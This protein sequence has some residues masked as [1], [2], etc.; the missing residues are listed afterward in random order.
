MLYLNKEAI[1]MDND[2]GTFSSY[3]FKTELVKS[4]VALLY[5]KLK[6]DDNRDGEITIECPMID[7]IG[8]CHLYKLS[9]YDAFNHELK[10]V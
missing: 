9:F 5:T 1:N 6:A 4:T 10:G 8:N 7:D 3:Y 2:Y